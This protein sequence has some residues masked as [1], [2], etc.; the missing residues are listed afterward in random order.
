MTKR[1][2]KTQKSQVK[3]QELVAVAFTEDAEL[4]KDYETLLKTKPSKAPLK[5]LL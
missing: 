3:L 2:K 4:A 1:H 5:A